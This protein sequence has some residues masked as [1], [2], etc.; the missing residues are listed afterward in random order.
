MSLK[1]CVVG[2]HVHCVLSLTG[3]L[4]VIDPCIPPSPEVPSCWWGW[5]GSTMAPRWDIISKVSLS[6]TQKLRFILTNLALFTE[7][8]TRVHSCDNRRPFQGQTIVACTVL[9]NIVSKLLF[10]SKEEAIFI[11][12]RV[13]RSLDY[14]MSP[15]HLSQAQLCLF[16]PF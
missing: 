7:L 14:T 1:P 2:R 16:T 8:G 12:K 5:W 3:V 6:L 13:Y 11:V 4:R 9:L 15:C 10:Y